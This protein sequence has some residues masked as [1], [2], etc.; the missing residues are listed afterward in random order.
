MR[1]LAC[2]LLI[3]PHQSFFVVKSCTYVQ[4]AEV[5]T[6]PGITARDIG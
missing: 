1:L 5:L 4:Q 6:P 2:L 3:T